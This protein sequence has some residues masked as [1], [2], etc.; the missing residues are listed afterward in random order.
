MRGTGTGAPAI[1]PV[2]NASQFHPSGLGKLKIS[3]NIVGTPCN[4][5]QFS[6]EMAFR[7]ALASKVSAGR[8]IFAPWVRTANTPSTRPKQWN[9]G[10]GQH[11]T[12]SSVNSKRSP[13]EVALLMR[14]LW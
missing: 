12:S 9:K 10:G 3:S 7:T 1:I 4:A 2:L 14:L 8:T 13:I 11:R 6:S 5:V